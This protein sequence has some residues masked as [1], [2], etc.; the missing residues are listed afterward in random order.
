MTPIRS[1][2]FIF[3]VSKLLFMAAVGRDYKNFLS[4]SAC[5]NERKVCT[6]G[7]DGW[8][9][10]FLF[11]NILQRQHKQYGQSQELHLKH[12]FAACFAT[13][14]SVGLKYRRTDV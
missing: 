3:V 1:V 10:I 13:G 12:L 6:V 9:P 2:L 14:Q 8:I 7:G 4:T 11:W 5:R